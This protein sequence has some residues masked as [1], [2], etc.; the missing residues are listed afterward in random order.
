MNDAN[1][2][3]EMYRKFQRGDISET[4]WR[5]YCAKILNSALTANADVFVRLKHR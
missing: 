1:D 2:Y 5:E 4:V 3:D